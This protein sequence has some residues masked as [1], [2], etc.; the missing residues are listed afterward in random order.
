MFNKFENKRE[1]YIINSDQKCIIIRK[2]QVFIANINR[3]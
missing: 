3:E 1:L 2:Y